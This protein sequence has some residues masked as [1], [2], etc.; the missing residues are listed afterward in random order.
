MK[1]SDLFVKALLNEDVKHIFGIPGEENIDLLDSIANSSIDFIL[2]RHEQGAAFMAD[3]YARVKKSPSVCLSTL[4]PGAT[5]LLT[6]VANAHL[7]KVPLVA[8]TAQAPRDRLHKESHQNVDTLA[9]FSGV[10]KYN[11]AIVV[12]ESIP[13]IVRKAFGMSMRETRG[14]SH[15][16]LPED[17]GKLETGDEKMIPLPDEAIFESNVSIIKKAAEEINR[18]K[19]PIILAGNGVIR[20]SA[21]NS[22][23]EFVQD[24]NVPIVTTFMAKGIVPY[25]DPANF[26]VVGGRPYPN[27]LRPLIN[28][29]L[30]I[31]I[32]FDM[33]EYDPVIWNKDSSRRIINIS[34]TQAEAD[35]H[36]P[37]SY[38][39]VGNMDF[40]LKTLARYVQRREIS[41]E[42]KDIRQR[43][44]E[45]IESPGD[46]KE[47]LAKEIIKQLNELSTENTLL[48]SDVGLHKVWISR[49]YH[50]K[51]PD[52]TIIYNGFASM[53]GA[54]PASIGAKVANDKLSVVSVSG[55]GGFLMNVQELE[56]AKRLGLKFTCVIFNDLTL[57]L[58]EKH[59][60]DADLKPNYIHFTN[61]DFNLLAKSFDC[62]YFLSTDGESFKKAY[63]QAEKSDGVSLIEVAF[64]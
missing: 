40:S 6:G 3:A 36:F 20:F 33:V 27:K 61:P 34:M 13:E 51:S 37:V 5:N 31:A 28:S 12:P 18:A 41:K 43:R 11:R 45:Y 22:V 21:W 2:T 19:N 30:I 62:N 58:I 23:K 35:E 16:Q 39:M 55:D 25:D 49:F 59:Q 10:T 46:G 24:T 9:L 44:K 48:I 63:T 26:F 47:R 38:D 42:Y 54:L 56:T 53:G 4:G 29:D 17:I 7:D 64:Q 57:S 60:I 50:P 1:G 52:R 32:G 14:A 8:I 15:I